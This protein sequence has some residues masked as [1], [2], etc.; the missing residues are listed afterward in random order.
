MRNVIA[1]IILLAAVATPALAQPSIEITP[2]LGYVFGGSFDELLAPGLGNT[3][4]DIEDSESY[5]LIFGIGSERNAFEFTWMHQ[6]SELSASSAA[7]PIF[8]YKSDNFQFGYTYFFTEGTTKP[9]MTFSLGWTDFDIG[10]QDGD[11]RF[12]GAIGG[13]I[14]HYF[15]D[16]IGIRAQAR[17]IPTYVNTD[18]AYIVCD[19]FYGFCYEVGDDNYLYQTEVSLGLIIK[20]R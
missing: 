6:S 9:F 5:G 11:S 7:L 3:S 1:S 8:D 14:N 19:P 13:G 18:D 16:R 15:N 2:T 4:V 20:I 10:G 12:S 17:W